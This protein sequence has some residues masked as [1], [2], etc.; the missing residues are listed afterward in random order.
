MDLVSQLMF[1]GFQALR[2]FA[3]GSGLSGSVVLLFLCYLTELHPT[4]HS[5]V[6]SLSSIPEQGSSREMC[7]QP[8]GNK[9]QETSTSSSKSTKHLGSR[10]KLLSGG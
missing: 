7:S 10:S 2:E 6:L 9:A 4:M 5:L 8:A 3:L 1:F